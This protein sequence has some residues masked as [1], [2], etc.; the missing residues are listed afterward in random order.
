MSLFVVIVE[1]DYRRSYKNFHDNF[2]NHQKITNW[3]HYLTSCYIV[4]TNFTYDELSNHCKSCLKEFRYEDTHIVLSVNLDHAQGWLPSDA[5]E[6][7]SKN[8]CE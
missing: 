2:V 7:I 3:W 1:R 8:A 5:W 4:K 6:W